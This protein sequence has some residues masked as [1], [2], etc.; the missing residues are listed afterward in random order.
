MNDT[1]V[2][3]LVRKSESD[4]VENV[5]VVIEPTESRPAT[6]PTPV[7]SPKPTAVPGAKPMHA[8]KPTLAKSRSEDLP[9]EQTLL[10][11]YRTM[12]TSRRI[13]DKEIQLKGQNRIFFQISGAG[14][15]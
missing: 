11:M 5:E 10:A 3:K 7:E 13:D 2:L 14:H 1:K 4:A 6:R 12:Y 9:D 8:V 15:E